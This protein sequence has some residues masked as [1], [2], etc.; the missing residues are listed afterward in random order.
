MTK[1]ILLLSCAASAIAMS[2]G[3]AYAATAQASAANTANENN[4]VTEIVVTAEK[5]EQNLQ[6]V[7]IAISAFTGE[8]R[9][10]IGINTIQ[11]M[12]NFTPGLSYST[13]TDRISLRGVGRTTNVLSADAPVANYDD[14]LYETFAVAAGRSSLDLDRVEVLRGPQGTLYGRNALAGAL[15]EITNRP[16]K[17]PYAEVR[18]TYGNYNHITLE[19]AVAGPLNDNWGFRVYGTWDY[20]TQGWIK[21]TI[22]GQPNSGNIIN[23]WYMD[24]QIQGKINDHLDMWTK[25]QSAQW[26]NGSG[27]PGADSAGWFNGGVPGAEF[28]V[29][30]TRANA[31]Y[32]CNAGFA[33]QGGNSVVTAGG[34]SLAQACTNPAVGNPWKEALQTTHGVQLPMY[35]S[36]NSQWTWHADGFDIKYIGGGTY[37]HYK[38]T[39]ATGGNNAPISSYS[40]P[41]DGHGIGF[42]AAGAPAACTGLGFGLTVL[43]QDNFLYQELNGFFSNEL[44]FISTGTGNLQWVAGVYQFHQHYT[45]PVT[46]GDAAQPQEF[47]PFPAV[48]AFTCPAS[49]LANWFD[50][51]PSVSDTSVAAY[52]QI[53]WKFTDTLKLTVGLRYS[54]DRKY[55]SESV[56]LTCFALPACVNPESIGKFTPAIDLTGVP[57]VVD[58]GTIA[59]EPTLPKGV[60]GPTTYDPATGL[61][62]RQY[63]ASWQAPSGTLGLEWTPDS[64][65]LYYF[66]YGR[67]YKSGGYNIGIFTVLSFFPWTDAEHVDSFEFGAKHTFGHFLTTN[68]A[69]FWYNYQNLQIPISIVNTSGGLAQSQTAFY[70]VP[71]AISRGIELETT[72]TPVDN[73][74]VTFN[75]SYLDSYTTKGTGEDPADPNG[76]A[77]GAAPMFTAA[78][79]QAAALLGPGHGLCTVDVY[80][81]TAAT[82]NALANPLNSVICGVTTPPLGCTVAPGVFS[83]IIPGDPNQGWN[84][85]QNLKGNRLPNAPKNKIAVNVLYTFKTD[86]GDITPSVSYVW[87]DKMYGGLFTR[88][89]DASPSWSQWDARMSWKS[90]NGRFEAIAFIK[91]IANTVGYDQGATGARLAGTSDVLVPGGVAGTGIYVPTNYVQGVNGPAGFNSHVAGANAAGIAQLLY[92]TPPRTFGIELHY[93]FF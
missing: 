44:T 83:A 81:E 64:D 26:W 76:N 13:S 69:A 29:A 34:I 59:S 88:S 46:A 12:T 8:K 60:V 23:E 61:A 30:A 92:P 35:V 41:C 78:Q 85:P 49:P 82:A 43:P 20:Q 47:G 65:S 27:G 16:T 77:P 9:D 63:N 22:P 90:T 25:I 54:H 7:P 18:L 80:T 72:W 87:R 17:S 28:S 4:G 45:Q 53:D 75:Y 91:N 1:H 5:R 93:K 10:K 52:A 32:V 86:A 31:G 79:C 66:K 24:A 68:L 39:G 89:Y 37:Y 71:A 56:R 58:S 2:A 42:G 14:N 57:T 74:V 15:N 3:G 50:N 84:I 38:L 6:T 67:G 73:L 62:T 70:N 48:C 33:A 11:D 55:G 21:N 36:L 19:G 40:L 51:R